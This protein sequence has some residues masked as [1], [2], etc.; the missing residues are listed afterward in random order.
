MER[1]NHTNRAGNGSHVSTN[2]L[3]ILVTIVNRKKGSY[4]KDLIQSFEANLQ[5]SVL[6]EGTANPQLL[7]VLD[8]AATEKLVIFS[9]LREDK[10]KQVL[11]EIEEKFRTIK[12]G[13]GIAFTVPMSSVIGVS[14]F[15]FLSNN[16]MT[17]KEAT[18]NE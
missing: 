2:A 15:G 11:Q 10:A 3:M 13:K 12:N 17:V 4:Y 5:F 14:I 16:R 1:R 18:D 9:V 6:A 8:L 7:S